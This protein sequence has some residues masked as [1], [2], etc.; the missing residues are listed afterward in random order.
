MQGSKTQSSGSSREDATPRV[1]VT[2]GAG[3]IGSH[4]CKRLLEEG[5]KVIALDNFNDFYDPT[6]KKRNISGLTEDPNFTLIPGDILDVDLLEAIFSNDPGNVAELSLEVKGIEPTDENIA[7]TQDLRPSSIVHL[8][9]M[10]GVRPSLVSPTEYV[11]VDIK[12]TV[13]LLEAARNY[14]VDKFVF[15][16]S[17]SVYGVNEKVP[18]SEDDVTDLQISPYA[19]AKKAAEGYCKTYNHLY[20]VPIAALR[21][22]TV[23][24]PRQRPEM[25]IH[26]FARLMDNGEK[27]PAYGDGTS[28]RDYTYVDDI[29][30]GIVASLDADYDFEVFNLGNSETIELNQLIELI[31][32]EMGIEPEIDRQPQ[33][34]GDVPITYADISKSREMLGYSP[35]VLIEE[36]VARFVDWYKQSESDSRA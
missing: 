20:G 33:Q 14:D 22:F 24:G 10:A 31:G 23:Y 11:D 15:G 4:L 32:D 3:F 28:E 12:G 21:F 13:N 9:A 5:L 27:I 2:G 17:S 16:S 30:D 36:G 1:L 7:R 25:A 18:F 35:E 34:P 29:V 6:I 26:K 8:A 19:T